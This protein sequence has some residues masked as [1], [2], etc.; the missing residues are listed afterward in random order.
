VSS[1]TNGLIVYIPHLRLMMFLPFLRAGVTWP[2]A[3]QCVRPTHNRM[4]KMLIAPQRQP[5]KSV[6]VR[7]R[8]LFTYFD[9]ISEIQRK[10]SFTQVTTRPNLQINRMTDAWL[11]CIYKKNGL[12]SCSA[13]RSEV[14]KRN[15]P[16]AARS[17]DSCLSQQY[18]NTQL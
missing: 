13:R 6:I 8:L 4:I 14:H 2:C 15:W 12:H 3:V 7:S 11:N 1:Y 10:E 9:K 18:E 5:F 17:M 16:Q